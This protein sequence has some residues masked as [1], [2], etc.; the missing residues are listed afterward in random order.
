MY[1]CLVCHR[2]LSIHPGECAE[3]GVERRPLADP[4][5]R[6]DLRAVA[7]ERLQKRMYGEYFGLS[8]LGFILALPT[9]LLDLGLL[10]GLIPWLLVS[11]ALARVNTKLYAALRPRSALGLYAERQRRLSRA[12]AGDQ[13]KLLLPAPA[14]A[15]SDDPE[16]L[17]IDHMLSWLGAQLDKR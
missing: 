4:Q 16:D 1:V 15:S 6:A 11:L 3:C 10:M 17:D 7:E 12:L 14:P 5:V 8:L 9:F 13:E 2:S